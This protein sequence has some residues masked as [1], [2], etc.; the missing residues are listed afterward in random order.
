MPSD[1]CAQA[2][3]IFHQNPV[4]AYNDRAEIWLDDKLYSQY[5]CDQ[6]TAEHIVFTYSLL[7][8]V[9]AMRMSLR[10]KKDDQLT[11]SEKEQLTFLRQRGGI[12]LLT[13]AIA[14][15]TEVF[16]GK[17]VPNLFR[18]SFGK[19]T[20]PEQGQEYWQPV[21]ESTVP[22]HAQLQPAIA[23]GINNSAEATRVIGS[24][25]SMV[26][27]VKASNAK[28]FKAFASHVKVI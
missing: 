8:C 3:A 11:K 2:L 17:P 10:A 15:C 6:T 14:R 16:I 9:E 7:R 20:S 19:K 24:F 5:F 27:A 22:F 4:T 18:L 26:E 13:A 23:S 1:T 25:C 21:V 12:F 28:L